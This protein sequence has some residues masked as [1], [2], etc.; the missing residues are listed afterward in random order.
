MQ[1]ATA[2][3]VNDQASDNRVLFHVIAIARFYGVH[4]PSAWSTRKECAGT[5]RSKTCRCYARN[6]A[7]TTEAVP[8]ALGPGD[9]QGR[10]QVAQPLGTDD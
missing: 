5:V 6:A 7:P 9:S 4:S 10:Q 1:P 3:N 8:P 2:A